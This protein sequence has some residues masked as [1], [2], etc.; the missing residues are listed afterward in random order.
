MEILSKKD[1]NKKIMQSAFTIPTQERSDRIV[2][3]EPT[4]AEKCRRS[5]GGVDEKL[6]VVK[7]CKGKTSSMTQRPPHGD[8]HTP[9]LLR[10]PQLQN[11][12]THIHT[13]CSPLP[14]PVSPPPPDPVIS[15]YSLLPHHLSATALRPSTCF[16]PPTLSHSVLLPAG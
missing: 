13:L 14:W 7:C 2:C 12:R 1:N 10:T 9:D 8:T 3:P 6:D 15:P 11:A 16:L 4:G 5:S